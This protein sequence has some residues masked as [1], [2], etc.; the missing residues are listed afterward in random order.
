MPKKSSSFATRVIIQDKNSSE[1]SDT[2]GEL[3]NLDKI[4]NV[5]A[6]LQKRLSEAVDGD[7]TE[8]ITSFQ[9]VPMFGKD[10]KKKGKK[11]P[12]PTPREGKPVR[13]FDKIKPTFVAAP[14]GDA[15]ILTA[16]SWESVVTEEER[17]R[18]SQEK[19]AAM[20]VPEETKEVQEAPVE[21]TVEE[22]VN[23]VRDLPEMKP[24][25]DEELG[26]DTDSEP[27][28][29]K[30]AGRYVVESGP[31]A[32]DRYAAVNETVVE[33]KQ[34]PQPYT[35]FWE[36]CLPTDPCGALGLTAFLDPKFTDEV[37]EETRAVP[38]AEEESPV[39]DVETQE[40]N[41]IENTI[42]QSSTDEES[43]ED[44][45]GN[46]VEPATTKSTS[47]KQ[48]LR[49]TEKPK[50]KNSFAKLFG[51]R[52]NKQSSKKALSSSKKLVTEAKTLKEVA[53]QTKNKRKGFGWFK[54]GSKSKAA[55]QVM[56]AV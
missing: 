7:G 13:D 36:Q 14:Q 41:P 9:G 45:D 2:V 8:S 27:G 54:K 21:E 53:A 1:G 6:E 29:D 42:E 35:S 56:S 37:K 23:E 20:T 22:K 46:I 47:T 11:S 24:L 3:P 50:R 17:R 43:Y 52:K 30:V 55:T 32:H 26:G 31:A 34:E 18:L 5:D 48:D 15:A 28:V 10:E 40:S 19:E 38:A 39:A 44:D 49:K 51:A 16:K 4:K 12:P 25:M 33:Q